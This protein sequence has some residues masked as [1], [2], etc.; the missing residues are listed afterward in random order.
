VLFNANSAIFQLYHG[1]N[2]LIVNEIHTEKR[3]VRFYKWALF[4][5]HFCFLYLNLFYLISQWFF[6]IQILTKDD[7]VIGFHCNLICRQ[8]SW[9]D[10]SVLILYLMSYI[11]RYTN[12]CFF[13]YVFHWQLA[14]SRHDIAEKL[15]SWR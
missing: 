3:Y 1:E 7:K 13:L 14:C 11:D 15:Q 2:K 5:T 6:L 10:R 9:R 4:P 12:V 8:Q